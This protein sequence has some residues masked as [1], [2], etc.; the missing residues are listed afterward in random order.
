MEGSPAGAAASEAAAP[1]Q[2]SCPHTLGQLLHR[3]YLSRAAN[4]AQ[5]GANPAR[6][7]SAQ[8][9]KTTHPPAS[10]SACLYL[11]ERMMPASVRRLM[12]PS[13]PCFLRIIR[14]C[15]GR[16]QGAGGPC[17][18]CAV[19]QGRAAVGVEGNNT[20][21][22]CRA[23]PRSKPLAAH[24]PTHPPAGLC[25]HHQQST[26]SALPWGRPRSA[27]HASA[28]DLHSRGGKAGRQRKCERV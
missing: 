6:P 9:A 24:P 26:L 27:A 14:V 18:G 13:L 5:P 11:A 8:R 1:W 25:R 4:H 19:G 16:R 3:L 7:S 12:S 28:C 20:G 2:R 10:K 15:R 23:C 17:Q 21:C 22:T